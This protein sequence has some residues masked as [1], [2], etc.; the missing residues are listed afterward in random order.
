[1]YRA[2]D[3]SKRQPTVIFIQELPQIYDE[4]FVQK[5]LPNYGLYV[6]RK[7]NLLTCIHPMWNQFAMPEETNLHRTQCIPLQILSPRLGWLTFSLIN[8]YGPSRNNIERPLIQNELDRIVTPLSLLGGDF[9]GIYTRAD[10]TT[11]TAQQLMWT[12]L[13]EQTG[14][15][16]SP[17]PAP[18]LWTDTWRFCRPNDQGHTRIRGSPVY[19]KGTSR[20]DYLFMTINK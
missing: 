10:S 12:Y 14:H 1:M 9:N 2:L 11:V 7:C 4:L 5:L 13:Q 18:C 16:P 15:A 17:T 8:V 3:T 20:L 6:N 19:G